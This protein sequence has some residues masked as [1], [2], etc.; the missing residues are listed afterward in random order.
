MRAIVVVLLA[1]LLAACT[2][3]QPPL[4]VGLL[5]WPPYEILRLAEQ[6]DFNPDDVIE[7]V[8]FRSPAE[9]VRAYVAGGV[10]IVALSLEVVVEIAGRDDDHRVI[11]VIDESVG[12]DAVVSREPLEDLGEISG[13][14]VGMQSGLLAAH[15]LTRLLEEAGL[16][17][18]DVVISYIDIADHLE[19]FRRGDV[20]LMITY[21]PMRSKLLA[22]GGQQIFSSAQFPGEIIDVFVARQSQIDLR[23]EDF[24]RFARSW[25]L[26]VR[27]FLDDPQACA[28][29]LAPRFAMQPDEFLATFDYVK[30]YSLDANHEVLGADNAAFRATIESF[31][32]SVLA[33]SDAAKTDLGILLTGSVLPSA[34]VDETPANPAA[35]A[36]S[37]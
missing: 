26:A 29:R 19:A 16:T 13:R 21:D 2:P 20:D 31:V 18:D 32:S 6:L 36:E 37:C 5:E 33:F 1:S 24:R 14:R 30:I 25:F 7:I 35:N 23:P 17:V 9:A 8:E 15:V 22:A 34:D 11:V 3:P 12:G 27:T 28:A 4:R 10:D